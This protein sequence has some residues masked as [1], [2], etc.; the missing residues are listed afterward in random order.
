MK[1]GIFGGCFNPPHNMHKNI[2]IN[3]IEKNYL[4]KVIYVPT[5][6]TY[7]KK[8]LINFTDRY[9]MLLLI[10]NNNNLLVSD[11]QNNPNYQYTYQILDYF[12][13]IYKEDDLYF[14]CGSDNLKELETW[15]E[16]NYILEKYKL[17]I[18]KRNNDD[19]ENILTKYK[20]QK[21]NIIITTISESYISS[22]MIRS[23]LQNEK[24][25]IIKENIDR[26][27]LKYIKDN[28]LYGGK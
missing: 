5:G 18:I 7:N 3:L 19:I 13:T 26:K 10:T 8:D 16:Y 27:V 1:I 25:D 12:K 4:D 28:N 6:N 20:E 22:S 21:D 14:I 17:L 15:K 9:N 11:I 2:A 24:N 23:L